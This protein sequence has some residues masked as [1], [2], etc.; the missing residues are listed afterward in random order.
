MEKRAVGYV[1]VSSSTQKK[2]GES[3]PVQRQKLEQYCKANDLDLIKI[4]ADE[5]IS[6]KTAKDRPA[7]QSLL[8]DAKDK[9]FDVVL[10]RWI[11]RFGRNM[12]DTL[13]NAQFL[14]KQEIKLISLSDNID[15]DT[16]IGKIILAILAGFAEMEN[17]DRAIQIMD[18]RIKR[19]A[20]GKFTGGRPPAGRKWNKESNTFELDEDF[21]KHIQWA[22]QQY[23]DGVSLKKISKELQSLGLENVGYTTLVHILSERC[24]DTWK[25][26][27]N[28]DD[29]IYPIPPIL[30][31][32]TIKQIKA[33]TAQNRTFTKATHPKHSKYALTG[34]IRCGKCNFSLTGQTQNEKYRYY[35]HPWNAGCRENTG[36]GE[37]HAGR[38]KATGFIKVRADVIEQAVL[39]VVFDNACDEAAYHTAIQK[40]FPSKD[41]IKEMNDRLVLKEKELVSVNKDFE[42]LVDA[43]LDGT[44][45]KETIKNRETELYEKKEDLEQSIGKVKSKLAKLPKI[46]T[47]SKAAE[48]QRQELIKK[49]SSKDAIKQMGFTERRQL[50]EWL[51]PNEMDQ[52]PDGT[53]EPYGVFVEQLSDKVYNFRVN[54]LLFERGDLI[55]DGE[56][57]MHPTELYN[58]NKET[59]TILKRPLIQTI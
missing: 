40:A 36:E 26:K 44:M 3:L 18:S 59:Q 46:E 35:R 21:A 29:I 47:I 30:D 20:E 15:Y 37:F 16:P 32:D 34:F 17:E 41:E 28:G 8:E 50:F 38:Q 53:E 54:A 55:Q 42:K 58:S 57:V 24:G 19:A 2:E 7:L 10:V 9:Q 48:K 5:G 25:V 45:K 49:Y 13:N 31:S 39:E 6:G 43:L 33:K 22:A 1:R 12:M 56:R 14:R 51:F 23:L 11:T 4:Y 27:L 52:K